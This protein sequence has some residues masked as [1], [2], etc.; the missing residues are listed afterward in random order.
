MVRNMIL[1]LAGLV[2][3]VLISIEW[4]IVVPVLHILVG[5]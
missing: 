4:P 5:R 3:V 1:V 2:S